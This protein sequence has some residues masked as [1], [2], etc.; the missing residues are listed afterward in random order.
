MIEKTHVLDL[1]ED[2]DADLGAV[3]EHVADGGVV[4]YPTETVYGLGSVCTRAASRRVSSLKSRDGD[5]PLIALVPSRESVSRLRWTD[6]AQELASIFWPGA[7]TLVLEDP[8]GIFPPGVR[9]EAQGTVGVRVTPHPIA[10]R[11]VQTLGQPL[12]STSLNLPGQSPATSGQEA[13]NIL[14]ELDASNVWLLDAGTLPPSGP[15]TVVDCT[16]SEP[17]VLREGT[18]PIERLRCAIPEIHGRP[19]D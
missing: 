2:P 7:L 13:K 1:R 6:S 11:L 16:G 8:E 12:T 19:G 5:K 15:S 17:I 9:N 4:A 3:A 14:D 18:V 10:N